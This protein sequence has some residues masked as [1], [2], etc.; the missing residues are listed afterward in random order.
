MSSDHA[1]PRRRSSLRRRIQIMV[2][3]L[4][5]ASSLVISTV[6]IRSM[7][8]TNAQLTSELKSAMEGRYRA[9][10]RHQ[11]EAITTL[12]AA[13]ARRDQGQR[14]PQ[15]IL[16]AAKDVVRYAHS[17]GQTGYFFLYDLEGNVVAHGSDQTLEGKNLWERRDRNGV[18]VIQ[19]LQKAALAGG[20]FVEYT[21]PKPGVP[22]GR[23]RKIS[24]AKKLSGFDLWLGTGVYLDDMEAVIAAEQERERASIR[25][26]I[27]QFVLLAGALIVAALLLGVL[28]ATYLSRP[29]TG[30]VAAA[31]KVSAGD[32]AADVS[33]TTNDELGD[34][35]SAFTQM[36]ANI[37]RTIRDLVR[38]ERYAAR[39]FESG[40]D[41]LIVTDADNLIV[42]ANPAAERIFGYDQGE[43]VGCKVDV[44]L[45]PSLRA[46]YSRTA[47]DEVMKGKTMVNYDLQRTR[48]DGTEL[49]L[50]VAVAPVV[51]D[52]G[53]VHMRIHSI[54]DDTEKR[55]LEKRLAQT[56]RLK[57][58]L[59]P[60]VAEELMQGRDDAVL[61]FERRKVTAF[62]SDL[63]GFTTLSDR[64][65]PEEVT[66]L[67]TKYFT[68]MTEIVYAHGGTLDKFIGDGIMVFYGA[69]TSAG[70]KEDAARCVKMALSMQAEMV[71]LNEL[72][73]LE[74]PLQM[75]IGINTGYVTAGNFGSE[76]RVEYTII[77]TPVNIAARL[78]GRCQPGGVLVSH[79]TRRCLGDQFSFVEV[80]ALSL[81]G[82]HAPIQAYQAHETESVAA[83][84]PERLADTEPAL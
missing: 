23:F 28:A 74:S 68:A 9:D 41:G 2:V 58:Y 53:G 40:A 3:G 19:A 60:H 50:R 42:R 8:G 73:H 54:T 17:D 71:K 38:S 7:I 39:L 27:W 72:W 1:T 5:V 10:V 57:K 35:A 47:L 84:T 46:E 32:Y 49:S 44:L 14:T 22:D 15:E 81:K 25:A 78:E 66:D 21:W 56:E 24:Y 33:V 37:A 43:L 65:E 62:F 20:D 61:A 59:S 70:F 6:A 67:L 30:L 29:I 80:E 64:L 52:D 48:K 34:L 36:A 75:R 16:N 51:H 12:I 69:P 13:Q 55:R 31:K 4:V 79:E 77:G 82:I 76:H 63:V 83:V 45:P 26:I 18:P 11:V